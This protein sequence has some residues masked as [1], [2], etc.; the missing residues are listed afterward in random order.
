MALVQVGKVANGDAGR[1]FDSD[2][3]ACTLK[4]EGGGWGAKTGLYTVGIIPEQDRPEGNYLP[5]ERILSDKGIARAVS[6][7]ESQHPYYK[8]KMVAHSGI[9]RLTPIECERLQGFPDGWTDDQSDT[10]RYKQLG[11][12]V[13]VPVV[14]E[15]MKKLYEE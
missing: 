13:S 9:R 12:T 11:N 5:R 10:Q 3:I 6:T 15:I 7:S 8:T 14:R 1:V 4:A 2:G